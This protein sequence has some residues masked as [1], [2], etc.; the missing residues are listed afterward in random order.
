MK[1]ILLIQTAFLGDLILTT[2]LIKAVKKAFPQSFLCVLLIPETSEV[3]KNNPYVDKI[4]VYDK[5]KDKSLKTF[6][7]IMKNIKGKNFDLALIPHRSFRSALISYLA[8][9]PQR[10][11]FDSSAGSFLFNQKILYNPKI[12]EIERNLSLLKEFNFELENKS[13]QLFP[14]EKDFNWAKNF[15]KE[16]GI[17]ENEKIV[18]VA[19]GSVWAT[20]RWLK[21][22]FAEVADKL[23]SENFAKIIFFG[24]DDDR[25]LCEDIS[26]Q[27]KEKPII[28]A[29]KTSILQSSALISFC[30]LFLS[31]D[32]AGMHLAVAQ[33]KPVVAIFGSTVP[34]FGFFPY[35]DGHIIIEKK[36]YCRPC[37]IH[38]KK[39]C[40]E[41]HFDCMKKISVEEVF[42]AVKSKL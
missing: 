29:G 31:N 40:P 38:G 35:G 41:K 27:M 8:K 11:G 39:K 32:T 16:A 7:S 6:F 26:S 21:E 14:E 24:S 28:A 25:S 30:S 37:G 19:P 5:R 18:G 10:I 33:K 2:P 34:E 20:K 22:R 23:I 3:L 15:L 9:I 36:L 12:H 4:I 17:K 42:E 1:K 13:P